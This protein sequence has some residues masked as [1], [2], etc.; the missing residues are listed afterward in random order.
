[1]DLVLLCDFDG[2][3]VNIDTAEY[4]LEKFVEGDW[5]I[6]NLHYKREEI[7]L[8]EC[9]Q[10]Q[11][12]MFNVP[13][14]LMLRELEKVVSFR[15]NFNNLVEF[16]R[17]Q[18]F[19]FIIVSASLDFIIKHFLEQKGLGDSIVVYAAKTII[20]NDGNKLTLP[21]LFDKTSIDFKEDLVK[22]YKQQGSR[23]IYIGDG[24]SDYNAVRNANFSFVI[25]DSK[26]A[27]LC[28]RTGIPHQEI[29]DFQEVIDSIKTL[30]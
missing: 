1:M 16:C 3:V 2:T 24:R 22:Y 12:S 5:K 23:V 25:K 29:N 17:I 19:P 13:R 26:L 6:F 28:K 11:F 30:K 21:K 18:D 8:E 9:M 10:K 14:C 20:K 7:S 15:S 4:L 27:D